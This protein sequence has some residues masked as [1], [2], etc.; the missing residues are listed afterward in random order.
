V[1]VEFTADIIPGYPEPDFRIHL[2]QCRPQ[3]GYHTGPSGDVPA[4]VTEANILFLSDRLV[5]QGRVQRIRYAVYVD[6]MA[7]NRLPDE[8]TRLEI[9]RAVGRLNQALAGQSFILIGPGRWGSNNASLGVKATYADI[10]NTAMLIEIGLS[11]GGSAEPSYGTHFFQDLVEAHIYPL[12][13]YPEE[14]G[15]VFRWDFFQDSPNALAGLLPDMAS[16]A[17]Y[18]RVIDIPAVTGGQLLEVIMDGEKGEALGYLRTYPE[19]PTGQ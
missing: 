8:T 4:T 12:A 11:G 16:Y 18:V 3:A 14:K 5:P 7:Y 2:L 17:R 15:T 19:G 10:Y 9:A 6:P 1:D 13:L